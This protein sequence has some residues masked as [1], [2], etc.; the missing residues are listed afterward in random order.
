MGSPP[1]G[2]LEADVLQGVGGAA[3]E[4][5]GLPVVATARCEVALSDPGVGAM[6]AGGHL[7][8]SVFAGFERNLGL[9]EPVLPEERTAEDELRVADL[10]HLVNAIAEQLQRVARLLLGAHEVTGAEVNLGDAVDR[11]RGFVVVSN[12]EGDA[13]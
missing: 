13:K 12:F 7:V 6:A 11:M 1:F 9:V 2:R 3:V 8:I 10:V 4:L 5:R